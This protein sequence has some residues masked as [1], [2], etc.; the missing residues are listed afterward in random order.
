MH[1]I[2]FEEF[3]E[4]LRFLSELLM[5][6]PVIMTVEINAIIKIVKNVNFIFMVG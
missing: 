4:E 5:L 6:H 1:E 3:T 2:S